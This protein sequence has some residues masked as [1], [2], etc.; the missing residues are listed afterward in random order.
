[1]N[2]EYRALLREG[3]RA[4]LLIRVSKSSFCETAFASKGSVAPVITLL[5]TYLT[6]L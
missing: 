1:M 5:L 4:D 6:R 2:V 3:S